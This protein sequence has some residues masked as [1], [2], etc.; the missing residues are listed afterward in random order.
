MREEDYD[1]FGDVINKNNGIFGTEAAALEPALTN[2]ENAT[3]TGMP[4]GIHVTMYCRGCGRTVDVTFGYHELVAIKYRCPPHAAYQNTQLA[5]GTEYRWSAPHGAFY[6][7]A[8]CGTCS[9]LCSPLITPDEAE[10]HLQ[11]ARA[12]GWINPTVEQQLS[13]MCATAAVP[14]RAQV[15]QSGQRPRR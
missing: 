15:V 9:G 3:T 13:Q 11:K 14:Y 7:M 8:T 5:V 12:N 2:F 4:D 6:P 1:A 10:R